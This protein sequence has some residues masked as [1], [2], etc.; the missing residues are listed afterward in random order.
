[1]NRWTA[2]LVLLVASCAGLAPDVAA[3]PRRIGILGPAEE[4]RFSEVAGG[5]REGLRERGH[6]EP[7]LEVVEGR[8]TRGDRAAAR[9]AVEDFLR[10]RVEV[11]F[12]I[13]SELAR[14][15][16]GVSSDL[17]IVFITPGDPVAAGLVSSLARPG[18]NATAMT[19]EY[20]ELSGKRLQL[21][22][23]LA[24]RVRRVLVLYDPRDASPRQ[25]LAA[26]RAA[27]G[28]LGVT[29][30][31]RETRTAADITAALAALGEADALLGIPGGITSSGYAEMIRAAHA[32]RLPTI[33]HARTRSTAEAL[34]SYGTSDVDIAREAARLVDRILRGTKPGD[35]PVERPTRV[36]FIVNL[37]T[38]RQIGLT[39]PP[40][41]R[42][43]IDKVVE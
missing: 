29:L 20:P 21:L 5:L 34:A 24:P 31:E 3:E 7:A 37:K 26:A 28:Q 6:A 32:R 42:E 39:I 8:V 17:P 14:V 38:A 13:G 12:V 25:G 1:M 10:R 2:L 40:A 43:R 22:T 23:E 11:A 35:L 4:P 30:I 16:R 19:F 9:A 18:G 41:I 33:V 15:A 27:A 36:E